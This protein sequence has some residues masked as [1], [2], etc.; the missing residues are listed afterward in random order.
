LNQFQP[1]MLVFVYAYCAGAAASD[2][3]SGAATCARQTPQQCLDAGL[4]AMGGRERL[5]Q[6]RSV[7]LQTIGHAALPEQSYRQAPFITSYERDQVT[8]DFAGH[9]MLVES[10]QTWPENDLGDPDTDSTLVVGVDGGV[11]RNKD[12]DSPCSLDD[13]DRLRQTLALGPERVLLTAAQAK[14]L[15]LEPPRI[16]RSTPH[17]V[18]AFTWQHIPVRV[19]LNPYNHLPDAVETTQEFRDFWYFWGD[20]EQRVYFDNWKLVNGI[21][22]PTNILEERNGLIWKSVQALN[23]ELNVAI[24]ESVFARDSKAMTQSVASPGWNREFQAKEP[25][26]LAPGVDLYVGSWNSTLVKQTDGI[27]V[28]E[29]PISE[30]YSQGVLDQ[31]GK[32]YPGLPIKAVIS[33][34]DSWPHT[35]G[36][37]LAVAKQLP[38]YILDLNQPLLD[39]I[40][41]APHSIH[42][43]SLQRSAAKIPHWKLVAGKLEVGSGSNRMDL[44]PIRG[45][46]TERQF[47]VYFPEYHLLYASDTLVLY[48]DGRLYDPEMMDEIAQVVTREG[49]VID[50]VFAM[51]QGPTPWEQVV[52]Q[53]EKARRS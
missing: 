51:H 32:R 20:V 43:D 6:L 25:I 46:V 2:A 34:S 15:R 16:I 7:R 40:V 30:S 11:N 26:A 3:P 39:K 24:E 33:T 29:A 48:P 52:V 4:A 19:F 8:I 53:L 42:P 28:L 21:R 41:R 44:Y 23:V 17:A 50:K 35:G 18:L 45:A 13:V 9:R 38:V 5:E 27:V 14:D 49:L 10:K 37:R 1:W 22:L 36:V 47:M 12:G 31:A